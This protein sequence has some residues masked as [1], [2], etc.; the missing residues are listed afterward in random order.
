MRIITSLVLGAVCLIPLARIYSLN[1]SVDYLREGPDAVPFFAYYQ[2]GIDTDTVVFNINGASCGDVV[3]DVIPRFRE[4]ISVMR[5]HNPQEVRLAWQGNTVAV[6]Q[7]PAMQ[8]IW[9]ETL[10]RSDFALD[11]LSRAVRCTTDD[12]LVI[13]WTV[14]RPEGAATT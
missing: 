5:T 2:Y 3:A 9:H 11:P 4:F 6:V 12:T 7:R 14:L 1:A 10:W 8:T 13:D